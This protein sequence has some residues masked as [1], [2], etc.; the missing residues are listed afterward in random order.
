L[1]L[2]ASLAID[3]LRRKSVT[4]DELS[5][6]PAG[7]AAARTG[8]ERLNPQ[9]P[10]LLKLLAGAAAATAHP[11]LPLDS[12]AW[13][14]SREWEFGQ[15]V[16][17]HSGNDDASL[18]LR[19]RLPTVALS[20]L[21]GIVIWRWSRAR[22]GEAGGLLSLALWSASPTVLAHA[23]LVTMDV[24]LA[25]FSVLA[26]FAWWKAARVRLAGPWAAVAAGA[27]GAAMTTKFSGLLLPLPMV[28]AEWIA[29]RRTTPWSQRLRAW[30]LLG[31]G[32]LAMLFVAYQ[33]AADAPQRYLAGARL[34]YRDLP[35]D[36]PFYLAGTF[37]AERF[38]LYFLCALILKST[39]PELLAIVGGAAGVALR[40]ESWRDDLFLWLPAA[41][42][43]AGTTILASD[44]GVRYAIPALPFLFVLAGRLATTFGGAPAPR[45]LAPGC[46]VLIASLH[47]AAAA[48]QHPDYIPYFNPLIGGTANGP[49]WLDDSNVDWGED[50][51]RLP[52]WLA[53]QGIDRVRLAYFGVNDPEHYGVSREPF[54]KSDWC[55][56]PR[57]GAYVISAHVL[58]RGLLEARR[59]GCQSDWLDRYEPRAVLG[60]AL[61]LYVFEPQG[62]VQ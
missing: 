40:R 4:Y 18:L 21:A 49:R 30:V 36:Y 38:P 5:H 11:R 48:R 46:A 53:G 61:Y 14:D 55:L 10:P 20:L 42:W 19:G 28:V 32:T 29:C 15:A 41:V 12:A 9:H 52:A 24:P 58:V 57:A 45:W 43:L 33:F 35:A 62:A 6:L 50:L 22:F 8:E 16:L 60:G 54:P 3:S 34:L 51:R 1:A 27:L 44:Q 7:L 13:R 2:H 23:R 39:L 26:L 37:R 47:V 17:F 25:A 59:T 56:A 31:A